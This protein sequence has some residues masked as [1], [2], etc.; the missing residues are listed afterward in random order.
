[1]K[2]AVRDPAQNSERRK[3]PPQP[4]NQARQLLHPTAYLFFLLKLYSSSGRI[5]A[6]AHESVNRI[7]QKLE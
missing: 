3:K 5:L 4:R 6:P 7:I 1:M 2:K